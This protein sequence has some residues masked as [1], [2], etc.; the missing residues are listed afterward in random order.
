MR[1]RP[2]ILSGALTVETADIIDAARVDRA[3][4]GPLT[5]RYP[6]MDVADAYAIQQ[7]TR[8]SADGV[9]AC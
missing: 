2:M 5:Q 4:I 6:G 3:P 8:N 9:R 1:T 7:L